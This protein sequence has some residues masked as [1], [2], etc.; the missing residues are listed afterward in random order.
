MTSR[1]A[2]PFL[3][4]FVFQGYPASYFGPQGTALRKFGVYYMGTSRVL[5]NIYHSIMLG[6]HY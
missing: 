5:P 1:L 6:G 3:Y 4:E 2:V